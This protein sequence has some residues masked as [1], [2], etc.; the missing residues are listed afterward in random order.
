VIKADDKF[1]VLAR[2]NLGETLYATPAFADNK[3]YIRSTAHLWAFGAQKKT[4]W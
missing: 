3:I 4:D 2:N 1:E